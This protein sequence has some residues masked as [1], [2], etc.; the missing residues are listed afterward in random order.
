M[1]KL[2]LLFI[3]IFTYQIFAQMPDFKRPVQDSMQQASAMIG[4]WEGK[5][6]QMNQSGE[7]KN[8]NVSENIQ[9]ELDSTLI[10]FE[11]EGKKDDG[12][13]AHNAL[14]LLSFN[15]FNKKYE[16]NSHLAS[17]LETM[18]NFEVII[19]NSNFKWWFNDNRGGTIRYTITIDG[20]KWKEEGEYSQDG[21]KWNKFFEMNLK[22]TN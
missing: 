5:G 2:L 16:F 14:G 20:N 15:P 8:S 4:K 10:L 7:K 21:T 18:A 1:K 12:T 19:P 11:G 17:G 13:I 9:W 6:W 3:I 22:R